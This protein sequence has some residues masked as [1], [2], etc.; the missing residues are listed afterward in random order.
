[1]FMMHYKYDSDGPSPATFISIVTMGIR[2]GL[3]CILLDDFVKD[4]TMTTQD[5]AQA[6]VT[7]E[8]LIC[9]FEDEANDDRG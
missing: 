3:I 4:K 7:M 8:R 1:M 9:K 5:L 6:T 2:S